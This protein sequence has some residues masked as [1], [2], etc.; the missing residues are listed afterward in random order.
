MA[1]PVFF[2]CDIARP[3]KFTLNVLSNSE[4]TDISQDSLGKPAVITK[5]TDGELILK[6]PL[7]DGSDAVGLFSLDNGPR[8]LSATRHLRVFHSIYKFD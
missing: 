2:S 4:L 5:N 8:P 1:A 6:K 7:D 3:D